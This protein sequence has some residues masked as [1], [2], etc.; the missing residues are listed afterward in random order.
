MAMNVEDAQRLLSNILL[1]APRDPSGPD[2][3][4]FRMNAELL[5]ALDI[6]PHELPIVGVATTRHGSSTLAA[7]EPD[8]DTIVIFLHREL[9]K[10]PSVLRERGWIPSEFPIETLVTGT[11]D[12]TA[13]P[14]TGGM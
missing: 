2:S 14:A 3:P 5:A 6:S 1:R 8:A 10:L 12:P 11:I 4:A 13:R 7:S 9:T